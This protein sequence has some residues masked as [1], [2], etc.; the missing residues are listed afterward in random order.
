[1]LQIRFTNQLF[2]YDNDS[3]TSGLLDF[4]QGGVII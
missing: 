3:E 2:F 1:M 4:P